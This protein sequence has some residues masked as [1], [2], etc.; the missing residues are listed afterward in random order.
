MD[1]EARGMRDRRMGDEPFNARSTDAS[2]YDRSAAMAAPHSARIE[3]QE[4]TSSNGRGDVITVGS[5]SAALRDFALW[6]PV[7]LCPSEMPQ[8]GDHSIDYFCLHHFDN[9][10][11]Q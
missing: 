2:R 5:T 3:A 10:A 11:R 6:D 8:E 7:E 1:S 4:P 9:H